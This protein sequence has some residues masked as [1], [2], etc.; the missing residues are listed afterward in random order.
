MQE[1][2][3]RSQPRKFSSHREAEIFIAPLFLSDMDKNSA[4]PFFSVHQTWDFTRAP[5]SPSHFFCVCFVRSIPP[6]A[7][8]SLAGPNNKAHSQKLSCQKEASPSPQQE[9][10]TG[11]KKIPG[12]SL[13]AP[14]ECLTSNSES[15]GKSEARRFCVRRRKPLTAEKFLA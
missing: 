3:C 15:G 4:T 12:V 7:Q 14:A 9:K 2:D 1:L 6:S 8:L 10:G 5:A 13:D 11:A